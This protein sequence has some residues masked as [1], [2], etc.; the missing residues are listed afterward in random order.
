MDAR[1][2]SDAL[3]ARPCETDKADARA[4]A[5]MLRT[6]WFSEVYVKSEE[7]HRIKALL[8]ARH[9]LVRNKRTV[10]GQIRGLL[11]PFGIRLGSRQGTKKLDEAARE[12]CRHDDVLYAAVSA[13]RN[14]PI[15]A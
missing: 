2:V 13:L 12:A 6:S 11:R 1:R 14:G 10:F 5:D 7:G 9:Q 15:W 8:S 4:L 3:K